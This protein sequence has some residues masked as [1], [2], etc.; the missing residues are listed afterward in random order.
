MNVGDMIDIEGISFLHLMREMMKDEP[1]VKQE[2]KVKL[3]KKVKH[4]KKS[5]NIANKIKV[6]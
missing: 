5:S 6:K 1:K 2:K 4:E 3:K